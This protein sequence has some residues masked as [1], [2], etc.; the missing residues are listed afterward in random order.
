MQVVRLSALLTG[1]LYP[2][3]D[4]WYSFML[5]AESTRRATMRPEKLR[6]W[7]IPV[8]PSGIELPTFL[9]VA[10]CLNQLRHL[11][12]HP[13]KES[14]NSIFQLSD[15]NPYDRQLQNAPRCLLHTLQRPDTARDT[16]N[17]CN[18]TWRM[19][20][21]LCGDWNFTWFPYKRMRPTNNVLLRLS[22]PTP[23]PVSLGP[24]WCWET[25]LLLQTAPF[26]ES[27]N[28]SSHHKYML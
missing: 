16:S 28:S 13:H 19:H 4:S 12:P 9:F 8:T 6:H 14:S 25:Y 11:V 10:Q 23:T 24:S 17:A 7:K 26:R 1:R 27:Y 2:R 18:T 15:T 21:I 22:I 20:S 3:K 5:E